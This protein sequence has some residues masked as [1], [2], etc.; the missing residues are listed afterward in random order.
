MDRNVKTRLFRTFLIE[1]ILVA[2]IFYL[3]I[4]RGMFGYSSLSPMFKFI[5]V[6]SLIVTFSVLAISI[7]YSLTLLKSSKNIHNVNRLQF[8]YKTVTLWY[9]I[10]LLLSGI[11][12]I[13]IGGNYF[14]FLSLSKM[15]IFI[16]V[17]ITVHFLNRS[18]AKQLGELINA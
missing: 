7:R 18:T 9:T 10:P 15:I 8:I 1:F 17:G 11:F 6:A 12:E 13:A 14:N 4:S 2:L 16:L 3:M 5:V